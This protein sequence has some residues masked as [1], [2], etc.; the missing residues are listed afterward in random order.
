[1]SKPSVYVTRLIPLPVIDKLSERC[2][3][4]YNREDKILTKSELLEKIKG[5]DA[6]FVV[7]SV[8]DEDV[9]KAVSPQ[10]KIFA[11]YGV[12]YNNIDVEAAT[13]YGI[14][15]SNTPDVVTD[16]TA[17][18]T[19]GLMLAV[20]RKIVGGHQF[21]QSGNTGN[22]LS[23]EN[24]MG[25]KVSGKTLGIIGAGRIGLAV[26]ERAKGFK[27]KI[28]YTDMQPNTHFEEKT[29]G[30][31]VD[32]ATLLKEADFVSL[33]VPLM[34]ETRHLIDEQE[35]KL[36]KKTAFLINAARGPVV[37]EE[38]LVAALTAGEI[39]GAG[40]DTFENEPVVGEALRSHSRVVLTPHVGTYTLD[41][42]V[43]AGELCI[44]NIYAA[45]D[46]QQP[47]TC[48]NPSAINQRKL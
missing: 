45:L 3:V 32:K 39:A 43:A 21:V 15:V 37:N 18:I 44:A 14:F 38:A 12:G 4:D 30:I 16:D 34:T 24:L 17:D 26:A 29:G 19:W 28:L 35:L 40:L 42:R 36:M 25:T 1:M 6:V 5:R 10:C 7:G 8:M 23:P 13:K 9:C 22:W 48:L 47:P 31:F 41:T 2:H 46:G 20:A 11:N 33:H 27:M